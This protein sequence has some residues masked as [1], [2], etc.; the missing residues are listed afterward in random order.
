ML[1]HFILWMTLVPQNTFAQS[2]FCFILK[3]LSALSFETLT[4]TSLPEI[5][6]LFFLISPPGFIKPKG[7]SLPRSI[8]FSLNTEVRCTKNRFSQ[9]SSRNPLKTTIHRSPLIYHVQ[10]QTAPAIAVLLNTSRCKLF[11]FFLGG[12]FHCCICSLKRIHFP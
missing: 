3:F 6:F 1:F 11:N 2:S 4:S 12:S 5:I 8:R 9:M 10:F 7:V